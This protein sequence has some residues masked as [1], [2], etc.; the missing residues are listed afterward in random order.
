MHL[1]HPTHGIK[2]Y[3]SAEEILVDFMEIRIEY[4][5]KRKSYILESLKKEFTEL[6]NKA[7]FI[8]YVVEDKITIFKQKKSSIE[9]RLEELKFLKIGDKFDYLLNIKTYQYTEEEIKTLTDK[10]K[11]IHQ[12]IKILKQTPIIDLWKED[13]KKY[14]NNN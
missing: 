9:E 12:E 6:Q 4:Y 14:V 7:K 13:I 11:E 5:N 10:V 2:K 1:F 3:E 8:K